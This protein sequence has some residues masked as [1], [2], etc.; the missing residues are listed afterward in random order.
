MASV[1]SLVHRLLGRRLCRAACLFVTLSVTVAFGESNKEEASRLYRQGDFVAAA[2]SLEQ[3]LTNNADDHAS[4]L[5]LGMCYQQAGSRERAEEVFGDSV[6]RSPR[7]PNAHFYLARVQY[8]LGKLAE[9][10]RNARAAIRLGGDMARAH[11]LIGLIWEERHELDKAL[12][13]YREAI[14]VSG[15]G[16]AAAYLGAGSVLFKMGRFEEAVADLQQ[17]LKLN[18]RLEEGHYRLGRALIELGQLEEAG[19]SLRKAMALS[20]DPRAQRLLD[21]LEGGAFTSQTGPGPT[22]T[23]TG[24]IRFRDASRDSG[25]SFVLHNNPT[26][27]KYL[28]ET[29]PGGIAA[30]DFDGD[31]LTDI[32]FANGASVPS[33]E[34]ETPKHFNR[35]FRN[36]GDMKFTDVTEQSGLRGSGYTM[37]AAAADYDNDGDADLFVA[38]VNGNLLYRNDG[39][40][41]FEDVTASAGIKSPHWSI[42]GGWLDYDND[43]LLDLFVVNYL[44]WSADENPYCGNASAK[45][46]TYCHP[47]FFE[48]LPNTLYRNR[49]DGRFEDVSDRAGITR[50]AGKGMSLAI[51]DYDSNGFPD[52]FVT[53]DAM[54]NFL[55][56][57]RGDGTFDE[58]ALEAGVALTEHGVAVS[59]MGVD[60]RDYDNDNRPDLIVTALNGETFPTF[61]N[62]GDGY[63][64]DVTYPSKIGIHTAPFSGWGVGFADFNNDGWKDVFVATS[65]VMDNAEHFSVER[66][67]QA[68]RLLVNRGNGTFEDVS[69]QAG[70]GFSAARAH[71]GSV[72][73]DF[74]ND[75]K[76][77]VA[78]SVLG[79]TPELWENVSPAKNNWLR[80]HLRGTKSNRDGL[81][82]RIVL[83]NQQ[84]SMT[85]SAG[86][87]SSSLTDV[88]FG[89]GAAAVI[90]QVEI[91]W[92][93]GVT[94]IMEQVEA[95]Q[96]VSVREPDDK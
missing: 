18:P 95:N 56:R 51:A 11:R 3:H 26:P 79:E 81:G 65:H 35:L 45:I 78:V 28:V 23:E 96:V 36:E 38:G 20:E 87:A 91:H 41:H 42:T 61:R 69:S 31:G 43:G 10:E 12:D 72:F 14:Q 7:D 13:S 70:P 16:H 19:A 24:E 63:F 90:A 74:N 57:N 4:R 50:H 62:Q 27:E 68:N 60:F 93:S 37:G 76:L 64:H 29:M 1:P 15:A 17:A 47:K 73:A 66:Y 5:L 86:Y 53:N 48:P 40:G 67:K 49:G 94:Q 59:S 77:D 6:R 22:L 52:V 25:L 83:D 92:P 82:V 32:F 89:I 46:R 44:Q 80:F 85:S 30:F 9:G 88:H 84:N 75:G 58:V 39:N 2:Q 8:L 71:R 54:P 33:L 21:R 34:K 55:F